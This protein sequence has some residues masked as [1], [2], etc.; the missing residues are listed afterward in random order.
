[1]SSSESV[2]QKRP[3]ADDVVGVT[4]AK[5]VP[6]PPQESA[7]MIPEI[8][9]HIFRFLPARQVVELRSVCAR[10]KEL[11]DGSSRLMSRVWIKFPSGDKLVQDYRL[12][13]L[14][15]GANSIAVGSNE[16]GYV[17]SWWPSVGQKLA[18]FKVDYFGG[19]E[20]HLIR[21]LQHSPGLKS[22]HLGSIRYNLK[23]ECTSYASLKELEQL[24]INSSNL[25]LSLI[26][27]RLKRV[28][29][30][31]TG[32]KF[33]QFIISVR[34]SVEDLTSKCTKDMLFSLVH[35]NR[36]KRLDLS[37][38]EMSFDDF[39]QTLYTITEEMSDQTTIEDAV[40]ERIIKE[41]RVLKLLA[42]DGG[43]RLTASLLEIFQRGL[44]SN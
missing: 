42:I 10:W 8:A 31:A 9:E 22:F 12:K 30:T 32:A 13:F 17:D 19:N 16:I 26:C 34:D 3:A 37:L 28:R 39:Q 35:M 24:T 27:P 23:E 14:P 6:A 1:M 15:A 2:S 4:P 7:L 41:C 21:M 25:T 29:S 11:I 40:V 43:V 44:A 33:N 5:L 38:H 20:H 18:H 36:L